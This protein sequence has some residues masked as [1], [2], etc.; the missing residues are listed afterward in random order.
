MKAAD[1]AQEL[2]DL[3]P[4]S[5]AAVVEAL[6][7]ETLAEALEELTE[8]EQIELI[9]QLDT[10]RAADVLGEMDPD[11]AA[12]L[13]RDLPNDV[14]ED[15]LRHMEPEEASDVRRLMAYEEFTAGGMMT[16][17]P[18][19]LDTDATVAQAL[20]YSRVESLTPALAS[21]VFVTRP[22]LETPTGRYVG[23]VHLQRL[24]REPPTTLV[25]TLLDENLEPMLPDAPLTPVSRFF[26][27]YNLVVA[28]VV[29]REGQ[30]LGAVTVDDVLDHMLP[31][32]WRGDQ[33][34]EVDAVEVTDV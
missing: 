31:D 25:A 19:V 1:I 7:D 10:E 16:P 5:R 15:L 22:P 2:H 29:N 20:A 32:D 12:D 11:D 9:S 33:M 8:D 21:M 17:E 13:I 14:A 18:I 24:L 4:E 3:E 23:A 28:P 34:D 6:D 27:T 30:L 26:A